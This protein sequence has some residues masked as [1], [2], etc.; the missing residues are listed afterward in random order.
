MARNTICQQCGK[1][2]FWH[3][4]QKKYCP[5]CSKIR[6][7]NTHIDSFETSISKG[8][9]QKK[10]REDNS[11]K[12][13]E[14]RNKYRKD[15]FERLKAYQKKYRAANSEKMRLYNKKYRENN[16][17]KIKKYSDKYRVSPI[18]IEKRKAYNNLPETKEKIQ[19][20]NKKYRLSEK[21]IQYLERFRNDPIRLAHRK[22]Q[23]VEYRKTDIYKKNNMK[24][25]E[26]NK[27]RLNEQSKRKDKE[28]TRLWKSLEEG[29]KLEIGSARA[30]EI[31]HDE[32][33]NLIK[34]L[35]IRRTKR[36]E[37][38]NRALICCKKKGAKLA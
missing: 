24:W 8:A 31:L 36:I 11:E 17:G 33:I 19:L 30:L 38:Y 20:Y 14:R 1:D 5:E 7:R 13:K 34:K 32:D 15:N 37:I 25:N 35:A 9:Y 22:Q 28:R 18:N 6:R 27:E 23:S 4:S 29:K 3:N 2:F 21:N 26:E 10:Y 16:P 12:I